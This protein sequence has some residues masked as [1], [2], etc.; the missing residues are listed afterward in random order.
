MAVTGQIMPHPATRGVEMSTTHEAGSARDQAFTHSML[1][2]HVPISLILDMSAPAGP[3]SETLL[4][5][6]HPDDEALLRDTPPEG[7]N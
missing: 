6:E 3:D 7:R 1:S 2:E 4:R 5:E